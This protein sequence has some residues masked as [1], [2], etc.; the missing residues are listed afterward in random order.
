MDGWMDGRVDEQM[1]GWINGWVDRWM[2][3]RIVGWMERVRWMVKEV[4]GQHTSPPF[5][6][7]IHSS[8]HPHSTPGHHSVAQW[9]KLSISSSPQGEEQSLAN[10]LSL[11]TLWT[12]A[13]NKEN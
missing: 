5:Q 7:L 2:A 8:C 6:A 13:S 3:R 4:S 9:I 10:V 1:G 12:L 11:I